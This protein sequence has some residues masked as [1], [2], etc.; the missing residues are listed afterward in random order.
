MIRAATMVLEPLLALGA[1]AQ[2]VSDLR[3][4]SGGVSAGREHARANRLG[5]YVRDCSKRGANF[6]GDPVALARAIADLR[7]HLIETIGAR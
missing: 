7:A 6:G 4:G 1:Q 5:A 3:D 2:V